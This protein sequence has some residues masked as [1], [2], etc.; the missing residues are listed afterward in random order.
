LIEKGITA[1]DEHIADESHEKAGGTACH[2]A[3]PE[4]FELFPNPFAEEVADDLLV[5][6]RGVVVWYFPPNLGFHAS[7]PL[8]DGPIFRG[9]EGFAI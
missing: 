1:E 4:V 8:E 2:S 7:V 6:G 5:L 9:G 3:R